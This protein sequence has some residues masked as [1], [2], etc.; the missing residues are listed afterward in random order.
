MVL[1]DEYGEFE[2]EN[3]EKMKTE[4]FVQ[5]VHG[6]ELFAEFIGYMAHIDED[7]AKGEELV[8]NL[9]LNKT[10]SLRQ[11]YNRLCD[12]LNEYIGPLVPISEQEFSATADRIRSLRE[13]IDSVSDTLDKW[14]METYDIWEEVLWKIE[15]R[16]LEEWVERIVEQVRASQRKAA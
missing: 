6:L 2:M 13:D 3:F 15:S 12:Y 5:Q 1:D 8:R 4:D 14:G 11:S 10:D 9:F 16:P 7:Y